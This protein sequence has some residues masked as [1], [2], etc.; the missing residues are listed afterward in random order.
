[1]SSTDTGNIFAIHHPSQGYLKILQ[2]I[3]ECDQVQTLSLDYE[4]ILT[5][6]N[7]VVEP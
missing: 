6:C 5:L 7:I 1:M 4:N 3:K 2:Y